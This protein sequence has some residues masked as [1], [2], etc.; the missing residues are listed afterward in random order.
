MNVRGGPGTNYAIVGAAAAGAR[1]EITGKNAGGDWWRI[2]YQGQ[3]GWIYAPFVTATNADGVEV[4]P[5][6]VPPSTPVPPPTATPFVARSNDDFALYLLQKDNAPTARL[7]EEWNAMSQQEK[8]DMVLTGRIVLEITAEY[9]NMSVADTAA[10]F[11]RHGQRLDDAGWS[12]QQETRARAV[13]MVLL[14]SF[15][16]AWPFAGRLRGLVDR[17]GK[18]TACKPVGYWALR[19]SWRPPGGRADDPGYVVRVIGKVVRVSR[20]TVGIVEGLP[21]LGVGRRGRG[22]LAGSGGLWVCAGCG[23]GVRR[24]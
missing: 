7:Q 14:N 4:A 11:D 18:R 16:E 5:T 13:L 21:G 20:E 2:D 10:M 8:D 3:N 6:P 19:I 1:L 17:V 22:R 23:W 9:C 15:G 24:C 12:A